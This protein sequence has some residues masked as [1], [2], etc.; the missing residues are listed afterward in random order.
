MAGSNHPELNVARIFKDPLRRLL[1][2]VLIAC[3]PAAGLVAAELVPTD[4]LTLNGR[5]TR[6][7]M[8]VDLY[9]CELYLPAKT[10]DEQQIV[11]L[12]DRVQVNGE[13]I[14]FDPGRELMASVLTQWIGGEPVSENL[15]HDLLGGQ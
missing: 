12:N 13:E 8:F 14:V 5:G 3:L 7:A 11:S 6:Q 9:T 10:R 4:E 15:K 1:Q 2:V